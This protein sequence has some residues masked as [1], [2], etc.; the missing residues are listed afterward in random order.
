MNNL[1]DHPWDVLE[2][3]ALQFYDWDSFEVHT[4]LGSGRNGAVYRAILI[5]E[6]VALKICDNGNTRN[7]RENC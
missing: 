3:L 4:V 2:N 7:M 5:G 6:V 1:P